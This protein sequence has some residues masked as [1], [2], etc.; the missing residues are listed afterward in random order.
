MKKHTAVLQEVP[1]IKESDIIYIVER[2]QN[3]FDYPLHTHSVCELNFYEHSA[4]AKRIVGDSEEIIGDMDL[5][6][7]ASPCLEHCWEK[8]TNN[9]RNNRQITIQFCIPFEEDTIFQAAPYR[10]ILEML[11]KACRGLSFSR[12]A[13]YRV[14]DKLD[15]IRGINEGF[16][17]IATLMDMLYELAKQGK[18]R[19]LASSEYQKSLLSEDEKKM[20]MIKEYIAE[21]YNNEISLPFIAKKFGMSVSSFGRFFKQYSGKTLSEYVI[22]LRLSFARNRLTESNDSILDICLAS[23]FNNMSHFNRLFKRDKGCSPSQFREIY[24]TRQRLDE[25]TPAKTF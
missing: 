9:G 3:V 6:L 8:N 12:E 23:G 20:E 5:V 11:R 13:I 17:A 22:D 10:P 15:R 14:Y 21:N 24:R 16:Y 7:I 1:P 25:G 2:T 19:Q 4:G 18:Y